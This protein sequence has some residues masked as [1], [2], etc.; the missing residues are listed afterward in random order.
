M[1][2]LLIRFKNVQFQ[3]NGLALLYKKHCQKCTLIFLG[4]ITT[5]KQQSRNRL[6]TILVKT[7][8]KRLSVSRKRRSQR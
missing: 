7:A 3:N 6:Q 5:S 4:L 1:L 8:I 2:R